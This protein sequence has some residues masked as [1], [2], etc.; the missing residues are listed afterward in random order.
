MTI[1]LYFAFFFAGAVVGGA[2]GD[3][4]GAFIGGLLGLLAFRAIHGANRKSAA[5]R[6]AGGSSATMTLDE[7]QGEVRALRRQV[8]ALSAQVARLTGDT[9]AVPNTVATAPAGAPV[10]VA[11][12]AIDPETIPL[13]MAPA[14]AG[15][16][17]AEPFA[18]PDGAPAPRPATGMPQTPDM[19]DMPEIPARRAPVFDTT[20][21]GPPAWFTAAR[22]WLFG[23]N[24]LV[25]V[26][27]VV[28]FFGLAFLLKFAAEHA[29]LPLEVR[30][31]AA[32]LGALGALGQG[33][34]LRIR[35]PDYALTLQGLGVASLY[36]LTFAAF[37][38]HD[39]LPGSLASLILIGT[40]GLSAAL[41]I[42]QNARVLAV[43]GI[44]GGFL[45]PVLTSTGA[46]SHVALFSYYA[47]L[48]A[49]IVAIAWFKAWRPLNVLG[50][51]FTFG[52]GSLWG[53][54]NYRDDMFATTEPFL[55]LFFAFYLIVALL[56]ARRRQQEP[57]P[58]AIEVAGERIDYVD[59]TL[60]FGNPLVAFGLQY[61]LVRDMTL[62]TALS[63]LG[64]GFVYLPLALLLQRR[65]GDPSRLLVESFLALGVIFA[66]LAIPLGLD[67]QWTSAAWAVEGAGIFWIGLRQGRPVAQ[68]FALLLQ[69]GAVVSLVLA[70]GV[71]ATARSIFGQLPMLDGPWLGPLLAGAAL[72]VSGHWIR[73]GGFVAGRWQR[74]VEPLLT[75]AGLVVLA[76]TLP[77]LLDPTWTGLGLAV[78]GAMLVGWS[79]RSGHVASLALAP[80]LQLAGG[81][82][83]G[84]SVPGYTVVPLTNLFWL[85]SLAVAGAGCFS[86][87]SCRQGVG[88]IRA[89]SWLC[90]AWALLWWL[91]ASHS[92]I[93][94]HVGHALQ[95]AALLGLAAL[96]GALLMGAARFASWPDAGRTALLLVPG[97]ILLAL[98]AS[99]VKAHPAA[100]GGWLAWPAALAVMWLALRRVD[101]G[102]RKGFV[103]A[104]HVAAVLLTTALAA[105]QG[106]W[107]TG[108]AGAASSAW[109]FLG[110]SLA[111]A[112]VLLAL[113]GQ[114]LAGRWPLIAQPGA[115]G[116]AA[117]LIALWLWLR[118]LMIS[119]SSD[120]SA[121]PLPF[122]PL[123]NPADLAAALSLL[124]LLR[125]C[126]ATAPE[127][128]RPLRL[129]LAAS[130]F[131]WLNGV[132]LRTLHHWAAVPFDSH[133][134]LASTLVQASLSLFWS[135]LA[136][137]LMLMATRRGWRPLWLTGGGLL[138]VVVAKLFIVDLASVGTI[139]RIVS[140]IGVGILLLV[141][142]Y[143]SP[144][145]PKRQEQS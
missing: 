45:A 95:I 52:I 100:D 94:H 85:G 102:L 86:A 115:Y 44:C 104:A 101:D 126:E 4:P 7:L 14:D 108:Q 15:E 47:L 8:D 66:S 3:G 2:I 21:A 31:L 88:P 62:G 39:L 11:D 32:G 82:L 77:L 53:S 111:P 46:G 131:F 106:E 80:L 50:F 127:R 9:A 123:A 23:G 1:F 48:N 99:D 98:A 25:R 49:G 74:A 121:A 96:T 69:A 58:H 125:W 134:M 6:P 71:P 40:C 143:F 73:H 120:G 81:A 113:S 26:G 54:R 22:Q 5:P 142:G 67:A 140:F 117:A 128:R 132:L 41:A 34:R 60:V 105:W 93:D 33:W 72:L 139:E 130:A 92:E 84:V 124:A 38:L 24:A 28:L 107:L 129:V 91:G 12:G 63:A 138:A 76:L 144:V 87:W 145:P 42:L 65:G 19:P 109:A 119:A 37:R 114:R 56:Y 97:L 112:L 43:V 57:A 13:D 122:L 20:P 68:G 141:V 10:A 133:A 116:L 35:R 78:Y 89:L 75:V 137:A 55:L 36:L 90:L 18:P 51:V 110:G 29:V 79:R 64:L 30:Y 83:F 103:E 135:I 16:A 17:M 59:G 136:L 118:F 27:V 70:L 61:L